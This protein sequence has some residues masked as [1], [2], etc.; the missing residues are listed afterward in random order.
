MHAIIAESKHQ[1]VE[2]QLYECIH[3]ITLRPMA[4]NICKSLLLNPCTLLILCC[5]GF[6]FGG[7]TFP[8]KPSQFQRYALPYGAILKDMKFYSFDSVWS[9]SGKCTMEYHLMF[10]V[11]DTKQ[12]AVQCQCMLTHL[13][14]EG[15]LLRTRWHA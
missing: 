11:L 15:Q 4:S 5:Y 1:E 13:Y 12:N 14:S 8:P 3:P 2:T 10:Y 9:W 7:P 6:S